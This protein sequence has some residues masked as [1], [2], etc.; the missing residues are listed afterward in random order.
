MRGR[1]GCCGAKISPRYPLVE[2]IGGVL[3][4]AILEALVL[5]LHPSTAAS[6]ALVLF[7]AYLAL[8]LGL[9]AA[10]FIDLEFMIVPDSISLG[11]T[12]LGLCT[13]S[14]R[15]LELGDVLAGT[16]VGFVI[17]WLP[18]VWGY[19][20]LR[21]AP[22]MGLGDAKL[23]MLAGAW[24]GVSGALLVLGAAAIQG[25]VAAVIIGVLRGKLDEPQA[26]VRE[27][28]Q[29]AR[30]LEAL[31]AEQREQAERELRDDPLATAPQAGWG[32][33]RIAF[34]PFLILA[35][36]ELLLLGRERV[37]GWLLL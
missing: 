29:L 34:G 3:A 13:F 14:L 26:V 28:Q 35:T 25:T 32:K 9:T 19:A 31:P 10:A 27:R 17:V 6:H 22:G 24:F 37:I 36:L 5:P 30:E 21:G 7:V 20:K 15:G 4:L 11:G 16:F 1:A 8:A 23:V 12:V 18:F 33:A 2:A